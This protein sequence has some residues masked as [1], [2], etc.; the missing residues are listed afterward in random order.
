MHYRFTELKQKLNPVS[1]EAS[2]QEYTDL[3]KRYAAEVVEK[4]SILQG[5]Y[6]KYGQMGAGMTNTFS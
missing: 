6:A 5:M 4:V 1:P 3:D 2:A